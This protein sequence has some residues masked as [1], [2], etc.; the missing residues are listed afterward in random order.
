LIAAEVAFRWNGGAGTQVLPGPGTSYATDNPAIKPKAS[1]EATKITG[2]TATVVE[3]G[4]DTIT[5]A[6]I[7]GGTRKYWNGS[8]WVV[9]TGYPLTNT[10]AVFNTNLPTLLTEKKRVNYEVW[11]HSDDGS[12]TPEISESA[13]LYDMEQPADTISTTL[14]WWDAAQTDSDPDAE[15]A[16]LYL[17]NDSVKYGMRTVIRTETYTITPV[18]GLF[19]IDIADTVSME[20][21]PAGK[22]QTYILIIGEVQYSLNIPKQSSVNLYDTGVIV[23]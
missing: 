17:K 10:I 18:N 14:L 8:T 9:S 5:L 21:D 1:I 11:L 12:T 4:S 2:F 13:L 7:E 15:T 19:E 16:T 3:T 6:I 20:L 22:E 23:E